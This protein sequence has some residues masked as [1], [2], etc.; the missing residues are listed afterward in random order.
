MGEGG[1]EEKLYKQVDDQQHAAGV[2]VMKT[3][4]AMESSA[5]R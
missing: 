4:K 2:V 3:N 1:N 5:D